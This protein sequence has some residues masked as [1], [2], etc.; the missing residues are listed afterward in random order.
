MLTKEPLSQHVNESRPPIRHHSGV[1]QRSCLLSPEETGGH[2]P[3]ASAKLSALAR[4]TRCSGEVGVSAA[5]GVGDPAC[6]RAPAGR[7]LLAREPLADA[8]GTR[9]APPAPRGSPTAVGRGPRRAP[10]LRLQLGT[11]ANAPEGA[12]R[13][14]RGG[15]TVPGAGGGGVLQWS[16]RTLTDVPGLDKPD[17]E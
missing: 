13:A 16:G 7:A 17:L 14:L 11:P 15:K 9:S 8:A 12:R 6:S 5:G 10:L 1:T 2:T 4:R 3:P